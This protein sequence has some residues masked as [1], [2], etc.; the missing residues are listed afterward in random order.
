MSNVNIPLTH[1]AHCV[2]GLTLLSLIACQNTPTSQPKAVEPILVESVPQTPENK[3]APPSTPSADYQDSTLFFDNRLGSISLRASVSRPSAASTGKPSLV[4]GYQ[5]QFRSARAETM[6]LENIAVTAG[7]K[8]IALENGTLFLPPQKGLTF[9]LSLS[10]SQ[11]VFKQPQAML[12]F[13]YNGK[14]QIAR[15]SN[16]RLLD[17]ITE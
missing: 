4:S 3:K 17:F 16:H 5:F 9:S 6:T 14:T 15:I 13:I 8:R 10:D 11:F 1:F 2:I 12:L 7:G